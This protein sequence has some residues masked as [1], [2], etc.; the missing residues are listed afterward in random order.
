MKGYSMEIKRNFRVLGNDQL[1]SVGWT[2]VN[3]G[4]VSYLTNL[5]KHLSKPMD[6]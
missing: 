1:K 2:P 6:F 3:I 4:N 5:C